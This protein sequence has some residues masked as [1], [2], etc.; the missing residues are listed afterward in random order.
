MSL[1][2]SEFEKSHANDY[3]INNCDDL[4][5]YWFK[6]AND[7]RYNNPVF[8]KWLYLFEKYVFELNNGNCPRIWDIEVVDYPIFDNS[9]DMLSLLWEYTDIDAIASD[10]WTILYG[11]V[12][13]NDFKWNI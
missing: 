3:N 7:D 11:M 8:K 4:A 5:D 1:H 9:D 13:F 10:L 12:N 6:S 2:Y